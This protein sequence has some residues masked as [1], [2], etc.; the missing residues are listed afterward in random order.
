MCRNLISFL[1]YYTL[2]DQMSMLLVLV[3]HTSGPTTAC[4]GFLLSLLSLGPSGRLGGNLMRCRPW[5]LVYGGMVASAGVVGWE[6]R[7]LLLMLWC[8]IWHYYF[9]EG[10]RQTMKRME[11]KPP[12][13]D[14]LG[15]CGDVKQLGSILWFNH[16]EMLELV[17]WYVVTI[18]SCK[19]SDRRVEVAAPD[20]I[21]SWGINF[22][23]SSLKIQIKQKMKS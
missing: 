8:V 20:L 21:L 6:E 9:V 14:S 18:L 7:L 3:E 4:V 23:G 15:G 11:Q 10:K 16:I 17:W 2:P 19:V 12:Y 22:W 13:W 1:D 5:R